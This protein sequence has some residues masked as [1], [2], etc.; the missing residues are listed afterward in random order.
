ML[1]D[2]IKPQSQT[3]TSTP[4]GKP[5]SGAGEKGRAAAALRELRK[6]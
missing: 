1:K 2:L 5:A 6:G 4:P 3:R